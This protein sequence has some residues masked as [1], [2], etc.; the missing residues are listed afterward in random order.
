MVKDKTV[1]ELV[2]EDYRKAEVFKKFGI[3]FCCGGGKTVKEVCEKKG[4]DYTLLEKELLEAEKKA[5]SDTTNFNEWKLDAL[6]D[7]IVEKHHTYVKENIPMLLEFSK[8]VARVHGNANPEVV[9]IADLFQEAADELTHH[10]MKEEHMLF[11]YIKELANK[12]KNGGNGLH[13][14]FGTV[15]NPIRMMEMEHEL[16]GKNLEEIRTIT[17]NYT[18][19]ED[20]CASYSLLYR[21][22]DEF[23]DDLHIH[24][25]LENNILFPK[26][27]DL[28]KLLN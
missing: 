12:Q 17:N 11:P 1:G 7:Y 5:T 21:L 26:A 8:K 14:P 28:E 2:A 22:L 25:H 3:D 19:P 23:E 13:P 16:V 24:I 18:L 10:M 6:A 9:K 27:L 15:Q 20:A 4:V